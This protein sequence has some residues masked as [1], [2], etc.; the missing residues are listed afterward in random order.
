[1]RVIV[2]VIFFSVCGYVA[3][4][5]VLPEE[6]SKLHYRV[7]RFSFPWEKGMKTGSIEIAIGNYNNEDSFRQHIRQVITAQRGKV[8][9]EVPAFGLQYTWRVNYTGEQGKRMYSKLYHF[10]TLTVPEV[11]TSAYRLRIID[12]AKTYKDGYVF[13]DGHGVLYDMSGRPVWFIPDIDGSGYQNARVRDL[14]VTPFGTITFLLSSK[15]YEINYQGKIL[16]KGPSNDVSTNN[17]E[18]YHHEFTRLMNGHYMTLGNEQIRWSKKHKSSYR[19]EGATS[20]SNTEVVSETKDVTIFG[21]VV[22]YDS[23]GKEVWTWKSSAYFIGS[24]CEYYTP[25]NNKGVVDFHQNAFYFDEK[26]SVIYTSFR[27]ISRI[28]K[29]K[30]PEGKVLNSYGEVYQKDVPARGN[31]LFCEQHACKSSP[32]GY[33]YLF[34]NNV[35]AGVDSEVMP[36]VIMM[37]ERDT[38][39]GMESLEPVWEY[40]CNLSGININPR[41]NQVRE[42]LQRNQTNA[43]AIPN[44]IVR[45]PTSGGNVLV[46]PD[47]SVFVAMNAQY[48]KVFIV[49]PAKEIMWSAVPEKYYPEQ[50][51]W[52]ITPGQYRASI[53]NSELMERLLWN[54]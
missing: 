48:G 6:G 19:P 44:R 28:L 27:N 31:G 37:R 13:I 14:K 52:F 24:D 17:S 46:M 9:G 10:S 23:L 45:R 43:R 15:L 54:K 32:E 42:R 51:L 1:M 53:I 3:M 25:P 8:V 5:Q 20:E 26:D 38:G 4:A 34:N 47:K 41:T 29:I 35:C 22:E 18:Q 2:A 21:T 39:W 11:D 16:W 50:H 49:N 33:L 40:E 36:K 30:Y 12:A 7:I